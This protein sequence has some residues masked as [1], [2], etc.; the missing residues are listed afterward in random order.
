MTSQD[1][2]TTAGLKQAHKEVNRVMF[3]IR[4]S[5]QNFCTSN[6]ES[7]HSKLKDPKQ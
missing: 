6:L 4:V 3:F 2:V 5:L 1:H 7:S